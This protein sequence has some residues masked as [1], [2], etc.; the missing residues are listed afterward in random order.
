[1]FVFLARS[2]PVAVVL[3]RG[4]SDWFRLS[5]W[6]TDSDTFEHGQW[7]KGRVFERRSD[8]SADGS[9]FAYFARGSGGPRPNNPTAADSWVAISR[10]PWFTALALWFV[11]GTYWVGAFFPDTTEPGA[12]SEG[13]SPTKEHAGRRKERVFVGG[14]VWDPS[15]GTLPPWLEVTATIP[16]LVPPPDAMDKTVFHN[17]LRRDGW[18]PAQSTRGAMWER[19]QPEQQGQSGVRDTLVLVEKGWVANVYGGPYLVEYAVCSEREGDLHGLEGVTW[20]DWDQQGRLVMTRRGTVLVREA[21]GTFRELADFNDQVPNPQP[22]PA[23]AREWPTK[24]SPGRD[25]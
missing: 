20:A 9:L 23:Q 11:G 22:S 6:H 4:P 17:R 14:V 1:L 16:H 5:V 13:Q 8:I 2:A 19:K 12:A 18:Q 7:M 10:P 3:R 15:L 21:D 25:L 24:K